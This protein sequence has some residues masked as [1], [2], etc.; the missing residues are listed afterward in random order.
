MRLFAAL[1]LALVTATV[2]AAGSANN[3]GPVDEYTITSFPL[4]GALVTPS[5]SVALTTPG[6]VRADSAGTVVVICVGNTTSQ[7]ITLELVAGEFVPC[8][9]SYVKSTGT[10]VATLHVFY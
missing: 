1:L 3:V 7:P 2:L 10:D 5:D 4:Y 9:V 6:Q 8:V